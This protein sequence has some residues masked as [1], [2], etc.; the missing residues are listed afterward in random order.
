MILRVDPAAAAQYITNYTVG[1]QNKALN[2]ANTIFN[3][4]LWYVIDKTNTQTAPERI[5]PFVTSLYV[6][7]EEEADIAA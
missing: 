1:I 6:E 3:E 4:L 7:E 5:A 2:D